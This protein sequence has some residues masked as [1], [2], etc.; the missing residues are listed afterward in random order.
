MNN[1]IAEVLFNMNL[2]KCCVD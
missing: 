2:R 1:F